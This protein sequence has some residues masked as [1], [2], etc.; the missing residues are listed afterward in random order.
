[1]VEDMTAIANRVFIIK[2]SSL[3]MSFP[4][5]ETIMH[6]CDSIVNKITKD[7]H[8]FFLTY[9]KEAVASFLLIQTLSSFQKTQMMSS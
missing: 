8:L 9:K 1:M 5:D 3:V 7:I 2:V 4:K 6:L